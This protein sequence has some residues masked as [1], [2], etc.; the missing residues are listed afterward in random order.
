LERRD[1]GRI[2]LSLGAGSIAQFSCMEADPIDDD[3]RLESGYECNALLPEPPSQ[4]P[5]QDPWRVNALGI[6]HNA[7]G[8]PEGNES[9][10][11]CSSSG[12]DLICRAQKTLKA[13]PAQADT[14]DE[15]DSKLLS[16][17]D[18]GMRSNR[19]AESQRVALAR[20]MF[21]DRRTRP[22]I[23]GDTA[24]FG[25][26]AWDILLALYVAEHSEDYATGAHSML[27]AEHP[28]STTV[29]WMSYLESI[30]LVA[31]SADE[32]QMTMKTIRLLPKAR[33]MLNTYFDQVRH[34]RVKG[35]S[36]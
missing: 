12:G 9:C 19:K 11:K 28:F 30:G 16:F 36:R 6:Q 4:A 34:N 26:G 29:R 27:A 1:V 33:A 7:P 23:F 2:G 13:T 3:H 10:R 15:P 21:Q 22:Q 31:N 8:S 18:V 25:E 5:W 24:M 17:P 14:H 20:Q 32:P 35:P